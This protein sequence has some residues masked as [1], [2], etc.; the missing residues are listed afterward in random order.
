MNAVIIPK[1]YLLRGETNFHEFWYLKFRHSEKTK[2]FLLSSTF[3]LIILKSV[4]LKWKMGQ[5]FVAFSEYLNFN[6]LFGRTME[7]ADAQSLELLLIFY[8]TLFSLP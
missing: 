2:K 3:Y 4:K 6:D 1:K 5:T 7:N 8:E